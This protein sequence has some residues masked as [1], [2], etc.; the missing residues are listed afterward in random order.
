MKFNRIFPDACASTLCPVGSSTRK[1]ALGSASVTVP[2]TSMPSFLAK[3]SPF[4]VNRLKDRQYFRTFWC[5]CQG[6]FE[7]RR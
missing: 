6:V 4:P 1:F 7:M 3:C 2:S 5:Y